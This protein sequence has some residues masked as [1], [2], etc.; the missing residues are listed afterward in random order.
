MLRA[1]GRERLPGSATLDW[2]VRW[3]QTILGW[4]NACAEAAPL[5]DV[6]HGHDLT[7]LPAALAAAERNGAP[8]VYDSH[9][10]FLEAG[11]TANRPRW[12][13]WFFRRLEQGWIRRTAALVTVNR[14]LEEVLTQRYHPRRTI[15]L[16][17]TPSRWTVPT[18]VPHLIRAEL[19]LGPTSPIALYHGGFSAHRGLEELAAGDPGARSRASACRVPGL[20]LADATG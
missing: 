9:E 13:R 5:A 11:S 6:Y 17:N 3:R 14:S 4:G 10:I 7:A 1:L 16:H 15:V 8:V 12:A 19:G 2:L 20:W 18:P